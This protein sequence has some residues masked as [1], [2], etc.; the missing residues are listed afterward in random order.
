MTDFLVS[1]K[2]LRGDSVGCNFKNRALPFLV[3][4]GLRNSKGN[5]QI[6]CG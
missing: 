2:G 1:E 5:A 6:S 3:R 4:K